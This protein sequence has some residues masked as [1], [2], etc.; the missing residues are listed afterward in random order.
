[1]N[2]LMIH[3]YQF[4]RLYVLKWYKDLKHCKDKKGKEIYRLFHCSN[5]VSY[6]NKNTVFRTRDK[7]SAISIM[8]ITRDWIETQTRPSEFQRQPSFTCGPIT[9]V[10]KTIGN[11]N[12]AY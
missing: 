2:D 10:S 3:S 9:G 4:I 12:V 11:E 6:E 1:M 8:K 7:N 5:C